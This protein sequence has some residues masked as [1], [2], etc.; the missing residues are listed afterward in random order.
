M[1]WVC[2]CVC[3]HACGIIC[4]L[5]GGFLRMHLSGLVKDVDQATTLRG[6]VCTYDPPVQY[7]R[8]VCV[9]VKVQGWLCMCVWSGSEI[10]LIPLCKGAG[11]GWVKVGQMMKGTCRNWPSPFSP[12]KEM[13]CQFRHCAHQNFVLAGLRNWFGC[14]VWPWWITFWWCCLACSK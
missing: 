10:S 2:V 14:V 1:V 12:A 5:V 6:W 13:L 8:S 7:R 9:C 4:K 3:V 11:W